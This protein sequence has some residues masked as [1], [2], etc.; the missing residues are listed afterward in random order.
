MR[1]YL[2]SK[3]AVQGAGSSRRGVIFGTAGA[4]LPFR[5]WLFQWL[6]QLVSQAAG[7][8]HVFAILLSSSVDLSTR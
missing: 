1:P 6:K 4:D 5:R 3:F 2:D 7:A 8:Q